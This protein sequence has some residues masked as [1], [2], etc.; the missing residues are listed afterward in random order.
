MARGSSN[1]SD[2][3]PSGFQICWI[4]QMRETPCQVNLRVRNTD[5]V[6]VVG[7]RSSILLNSFPCVIV[8]P[9]VLGA[10]ELSFSDE[11][12]GIRHACLVWSNRQI[13]TDFSSVQIIARGQ[14]FKG[15][16]EC[17]YG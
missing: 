16:L 3:E 4:Q 8:I 6:G 7:D 1:S 17:F 11:T 9:A 14:R 5:G 15:P 13:H 10:R 2:R 12:S